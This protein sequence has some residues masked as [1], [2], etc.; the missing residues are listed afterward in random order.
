MD[1]SS[2]LE[3]V[4]ILVVLIHAIFKRHRARNPKQFFCALAP[5][6]VLGN[7]FTRLLFVTKYVAYFPNRFRLLSRPDSS[8]RLC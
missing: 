8:L 2:F 5:V 1:M 3:L 6:G 7:A 4:G